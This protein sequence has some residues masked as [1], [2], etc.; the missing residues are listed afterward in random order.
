MWCYIVL[1]C[2]AGVSTKITELFGG[3]QVFLVIGDLG[4]NLKVYPLIERIFVQN[5]AKIG[6]GDL[7]CFLVVKW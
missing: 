3:G 1:L 4:L 2:T 7:S 5:N 6:D